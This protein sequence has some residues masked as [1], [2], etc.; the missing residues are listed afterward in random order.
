MAGL[1]DFG[2]MVLVDFGETLVLVAFQRMFWL[3]LGA[4]VLLFFWEPWFWLILGGLWFQ[5]LLGDHG[6]G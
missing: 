5:L 4:M 3:L 1:A 6:F 2:D